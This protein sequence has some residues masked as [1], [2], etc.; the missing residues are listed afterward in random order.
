[1]WFSRACDGQTIARV[2]AAWQARRVE[3][4]ERYLGVMIGKRGDT[5]RNGKLL[6]EKIKTKLSGWK[7]NML[8]HAGRMIMIKA[9]LMSIPVYAMSLEMLPKGVINEINKLLAKFLWGK[10][11][12]DRY[13]TFISWH[14]VCKP[15][16][17]G[18]LGIKNLEKF[19]EV[20]F[21]KVVWSVMA[22][23]NKLW[24]QLCK[25]KYCPTVGFWR[26]QN[27]SGASKLWQ[28]ILKM[29]EVFRNQ[30]RW[31]LGNGSKVLAL[32][33]PWFDDWSVQWEA[34]HADR[35]LKVSSLVD[36]HSGNWNVTELS[37]LFTPYQVQRIVAISNKPDAQSQVED[38]LIWKNSQSGKYSV[39][40]GYKELTKQTNGLAGSNVQWNLI[41]KCKN[42]IPKIKIFL[43][44][45]LHKGLP[46][47]TNMH[48]RMSN[49]SP[50]CQRCH[51]E[52]EFEMHCMF[53]CN[54][55]RQVWFA[56]P[57]GVRVHA[58]PMDIVNTIQQM[59][60][61]LDEEGIKIFAQTLWEIWKQRNK[62]VMEHGPF[63]M[64][65]VL[66]R[67]QVACNP[68]QERINEVHT[69]GTRMHEKYEYCS[70][71]WQV[72]NPFHAEASAL[73]E[74]MNYVY[75]KMGL[76]REIRVQFFSDCMNLVGAVNQ[77]DLTE[78]PSWRAKD[79]VQQIITRLEEG[80]E[81]LD[82][83]FVQAGT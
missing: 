27:A 49:F 15:V 60:G 67:V 36:E 64:R 74:A 75:D 79:T 58:L 72:H 59:M 31:Q 6:L 77:D 80:Y 20:L 73:K 10:T 78:L 57:L 11:N 35:K 14:K 44:R 32:S 3:D 4:D 83:E 7:S 37:R 42:I 65:E 26:A 19:G 71:G 24:V 55:S 34:T 33:Q 13:M 22:D 16:E 51:E 29:R 30:V 2:Q 39:K 82:I 12:Q 5:K 66:Q 38:T 69:G 76:A 68:C 18:G 81:G 62:V 54:T 47:A 63:D 61:T 21:L 25:S 50:A 40:E 17:D 23:E 45:L 46:L 53:F 48:A 8:P 56:S 70:E 52:N 43:W 41:W 28:Q 1:M 9:V